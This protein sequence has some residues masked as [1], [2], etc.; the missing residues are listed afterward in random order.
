MFKMILL[1]LLLSFIGYWFFRDQTDLRQFDP[2]LMAFYETRS[3]K[4]YYEHEWIQLGRYLYLT[5][6]DE[7]GFSPWNSIR[8]G[9]HATLAAK[10]FRIH[11]N[12]DRS[13]IIQHLIHYYEIIASHSEIR[14]SPEKCATLEYEWWQM[15]RD[16]RP[17]HEIT[18][19]IASLLSEIYQ[20][21]LSSFTPCATLR[22]EMMSFRD[23]RRN[24]IILPSEWDFIQSGL[25]QSYEL[26]QAKITP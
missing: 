1:V 25:L 26:L 11:G 12:M 24:Q 13:S 15:R 2:K 14:M 17:M 10:D 3:W 6:R 21:P 4:A 20:R 8:L 22:V 7:Y 19:T 16:K 9:Y 18:E 23:E 5:S